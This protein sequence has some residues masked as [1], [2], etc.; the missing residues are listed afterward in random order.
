MISY[1][2]VRINIEIP[3]KSGIYIKKNIVII[4][5]GKKEDVLKRLKQKFEYDGPFMERMLSVDPTGY[6]YVDYIGKQLEKVILALA[7]KKGGLNVSQQEAIQNILSPLIIWFNNNQDKITED[8]VW[9]AE[10]QFRERTGFVVDN[11]EK[12][13]NSPKDIN[14]YENPK[15]LESVMEV[16]NSR[17]TNK[18][19]E[20]EAKSQAEKLYEDNE[21][22]VIRPKSFAASCYYGANTKWCTSSKENSSYYE[23]YNR[24]GKLYY[25]IDKKENIK[26]ALFVSNDKKIEVYNALDREIGIKGLRETFPSQNVLI[27]DLIGV[28]NFIKKLKEYS[29]GKIDIYDLRDSDS[30]ISRVTQYNPHGQSEIVI[31][32]GDDNE[33]L[34]QLDLTDDDIWFLN[35]I[36]SSYS[37]YEFMGS[38]TVDDDFKNG[39][40]FYYELNKENRETFKKIAEI[41][42]PDK[43]YNIDDEDYRIDLNNKLMDIFPKQIEWILSD[44]QDEKNSEMFSAAK[45]EIEGELNSVLESSDLEFYSSYDSIVTT[46]AN[47]LSWSARLGIYNT[48]AKSLVNQILETVNT[49]RIGGWMENYYEYQNPEYFDSVSFNNTVSRRFDEILEELEEDENL[50]E[51][52]VLRDR[53]IKKFKLNTWYVLPK[54]KTIKFS[55][56]GFNKDENEIIVS[57]VKEGGSSKKVSVSEE[58]F[59]NLLYQ[60]ELF[61]LFGD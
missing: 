54:D 10:T 13:V 50:S 46:V 38:D 60:P 22:L 2:K 31:E 49:G 37:N 6:K 8:D 55:I 19:I 15:F 33:L 28:G 12:I 14:L 20:R 45:E 51:F 17:K 53:I 5:E 1:T 58:N 16:V 25:F 4:I 48:D 43:E 3:N 18:E 30:S 11:I 24:D 34:G 27:D 26:L 61:D 35:V 52:L 29:R 32:Y 7:G 21:I 39:H 23:K 57:I 59:Y 44:Y 56:K 41:V 36:N 42:Y 47:L 40:L 9:R